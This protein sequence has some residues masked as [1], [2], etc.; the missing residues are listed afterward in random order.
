MNPHWLG[1]VAAVL[2]TVSFVPQALKALRTRDTG[3]ISLGMYITFTVGIAF[4]LAYGVALGSWPMIVS[5]LI[6]LGLAGAIL[7]MKLRFG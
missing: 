6:T 2:T 3:S 5:N 1:T 4:W 7:A